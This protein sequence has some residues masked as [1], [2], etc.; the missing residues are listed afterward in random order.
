MYWARVRGGVFGGLLSVFHDLILMV[1]LFNDSAYDATISWGL[2]CG[3]APGSI[4][5]GVDV[6]CMYKLID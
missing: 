5:V 6:V 4:G 1:L 3:A 2:C